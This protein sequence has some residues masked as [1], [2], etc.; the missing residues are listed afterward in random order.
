VQLDYSRQ[1]ARL[2]KM[3]HQ[4]DG[5]LRE[6]VSRG[7][8]SFIAMAE[9]RHRCIPPVNFDTS[10]MR[11]KGVAIRSEY[12]SDREPLLRSVCPAPC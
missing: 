10:P 9:G 3:P 4:R 2:P 11:N 1:R 7:M 8:A 12:R 6:G 5:L